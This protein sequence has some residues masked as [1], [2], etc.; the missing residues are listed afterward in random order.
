MGNLL[1][2]DGNSKISFIGS[3]GV[4]HSVE[5]KRQYTGGS[6]QVTVDVTASTSYKPGFLFENVKNKAETITY[7]G[8]TNNNDEHMEGKITVRVT[9]DSDDKITLTVPENIHINGNVSFGLIEEVGA[10][11]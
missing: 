8:I 2:T 9:L 6:N 10:N 1:A 3:K 5:I 4:P 11:L 7:L